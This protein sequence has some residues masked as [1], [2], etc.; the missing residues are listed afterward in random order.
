MTTSTAASHRHRQPHRRGIAMVMVLISVAL[1]TI[2]AASYLASRDNSGPIGRNVADSSAA[3]SAAISGL[4]QA[5][6]IME[7]P[8]GWRQ[9][10]TSS[11]GTLLDDTTPD[12]GHITATL[13]DLTTGSLPSPESTYFDLEVKG[14]SGG[15]AQYI[16]ATA[17]VP[18]HL[19]LGEVAAVDLA[20]FAVA[21]DEEI[22][23]D[24]N[25]RIDRW[26]TSPLVGLRRRTNLAIGATGAGSVV[27]G[28]TALVVDGTLYHDDS[29]S[30]PVV[31]YPSPANPL[32]LTLKAISR[33]P[34]PG[35]P[36]PS[37]S[38]PDLSDDLDVGSSITITTNREYN[39]VT[40]SS[41]KTL[42]L[43]GPLW[44]VIEDDL[45]LE[46]NAKIV[47]EN[48]VE[49]IAY[50]DLTLGTGASILTRNG[51]LKLFV[52]DDFFCQGAFV[53]D[54][55]TAGTTSVP[56]QHPYSVPMQIQIGEITGVQIDTRTWAIDGESILKAS[57]YGPTAEATFS[58]DAILYGRIAA[59]KA[60]FHDDSALF[61]DHALDLRSGY[62]TPGS[63]VFQSGS[64]VRSQIAALP[65]LEPNDLD[66]LAAA[67]QFVILANGD[68]YDDHHTPPSAVGTPT[69]RIAPVECTIHAVG[70]SAVAG[71]HPLEAP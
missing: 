25:A 62:A 33:L 36:P 28:S 23:L 26:R 19:P 54:E 13:S 27:V 58:D 32:P 39:D 70:A 51:S 71:V 37:R 12:G 65:T 49:L 69:P 55:A 10:A 56:G 47:I 38:R 1:A 52:G 48:A 57:L 43:R 18:V 17:Y 29:A 6:A 68:V 34:M 2:L 3:R 31:S 60:R 16:S 11:V 67:L 7:T 14:E 35:P 4:N 46:P 8:T 9:I 45:I 42:T 53:G 41:G 66:D 61:Y 21:A 24:G 22:T 50:N 5:L 40:V 64:T 20:E 44:L 63:G 30:T 59:L 15:V